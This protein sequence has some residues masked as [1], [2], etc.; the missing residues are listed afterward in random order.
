MRPIQNRPEKNSGRFFYSSFS[1]GISTSIESIR[2]SLP[3]M[4]S[5]KPPHSGHITWK[6]S[7]VNS[8]PH[9]TQR[10]FG[11]TMVM[12]S[13]D[14][15]NS[16]SLSV[17]ASYAKAESVLDGLGHLAYGNRHFQY[18]VGM[19]RL[20]RLAHA[21]NDA[22]HHSKLMHDYPFRRS[23]ERR[24]EL[25]LQSCPA[26]HLGPSDFTLRSAATR[27]LAFGPTCRTGQLFADFSYQVRIPKAP[28]SQMALS[29]SRPGPCVP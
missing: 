18:L 12:S 9:S 3:S 28:P 26:R 23:A 27:R 24:N 11:D 20:S 2:S 8:W 7:W 22:R 21:L 6:R 13:F 14:P 4:R 16:E 19:V 25:T 15:E 5:A 10:L 1:S 29:V 17:M